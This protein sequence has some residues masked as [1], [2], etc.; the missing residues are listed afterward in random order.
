MNSVQLVGVIVSDVKVFTVGAKQS[1][2]IALGLRVNRGY[3]D[4][5][6]MPEYDF[7]QVKA[8][9]AQGEYIKKYYQRGD[10]LAIKGQL[11]IVR[12]KM[13]NGKV[14]INPF[15][16]VNEVCF[17]GYSYGKIHRIYGLGVEK[18]VKEGA[19]VALKAAKATPPPP[20]PPTK[21][22]DADLGDF[23]W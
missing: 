6:G 11:R 1:Q 13:D 23:K 3:K 21:E 10:V 4:K 15:V 18:V 7:I 22:D 14:A 20:P 12:R 8:F 9:D 17:A 2:M 16:L 5:A 19:K